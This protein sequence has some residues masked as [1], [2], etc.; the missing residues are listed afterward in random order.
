[1]HHMTASAIHRE[2]MTSAKKLLCVYLQH[3]NQAQGMFA[4]LCALI[5][6]ETTLEQRLAMED[7]LTKAGQS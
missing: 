5:H 4:M 2:V 1:M 7:Q 6:A 3:L